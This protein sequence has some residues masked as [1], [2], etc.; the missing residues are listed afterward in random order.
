MPGMRLL[1][2]LAALAVATVG[3]IAS[4][5]RAA[6]P[7]GSTSCPGVAPGALLGDP[8]GNQYT[9]GFFFSG[10]KGKDK[11]TYFGTVGDLVLSAPGTKTWAGKSG[12]AARD[13]NGHVVGHFVY[14]FRVETPNADSFALVRVDK[15]IKWSAG[16]CH[17][18]GP[19]GVYKDTSLT[20]FPVQLYGQGIPFSLFLPARTGVADNSADPDQVTVLG[21]AD[22]FAT[23]LGDDGAPVLSGGLAVGFMTTAVSVG[24][25]PPQSGIQVRR[26]TPLVVKAQKATGL[27]LTLLTSRPL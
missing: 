6:Q 18:G 21:P 27:K 24:G 5:A 2:I 25:V 7:F 26:V 3:L 12:P 15:G 14:A 16:V 13:S 10:V 1:S 19:T 20:P 23:G 11:A 4:P 17:F 8:S 9:M 22:A